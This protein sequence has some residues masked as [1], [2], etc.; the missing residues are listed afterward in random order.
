LILSGDGLDEDA[1]DDPF[2]ASVLL[3]YDEPDVFDLED[4]QAVS[5]DARSPPRSHSR[6]PDRQFSQPDDDNDEDSDS[7]HHSDEDESDSQIATRTLAASTPAETPTPIVAASPPVQVAPTTPAPVIIHS[8]APS[9]VRSEPAAS[10]PQL[11]TPPITAKRTK[12]SRR[13]VSVDIPAP[14]TPSSSRAVPAAPPSAP[15]KAVPTGIRPS[16]QSPPRW[17]GD[18]TYGNP[19]YFSGNEVTSNVGMYRHAHPTPQN[20]DRKPA[21]ALRD[22]KGLYVNQHQ[23]RWPVPAG[24]L[25]P[26]VLQPD[27]FTYFKI[28][29]DETR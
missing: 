22:R 15:Q 2:E 28:Y 29:F 21:W 14:S 20:L 11:A 8:L 17:L 10:N 5:Y 13:E 24:T 25:L 3:D 18:G 19:Y 12:A 4:V 16:V 1:P 26:D 23:T 9:L 7:S 6:S 27:G